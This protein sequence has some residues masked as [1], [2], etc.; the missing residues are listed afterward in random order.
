MDRRTLTIRLPE[1]GTVSPAALL[2]AAIERKTC[3]QAIYNRTTIKLA[4]YALYTKHAD[5]FVDGVVVE[6][7][8]QPP[9]ELKIGTFKIA[10]LKELASTFMGFRPEPIFDPTAPKYGGD[11]V[12][13]ALP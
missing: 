10:G 3:V 1:P 6:R 5:A 8:G 11:T 12:L 7:D 2:R 13:T 4:P 9:R